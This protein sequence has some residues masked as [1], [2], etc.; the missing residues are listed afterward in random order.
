MIICD[1]WLNNNPADSEE[2][3][4]SLQEQSQKLF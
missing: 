2:I 1:Y 3:I 4:F